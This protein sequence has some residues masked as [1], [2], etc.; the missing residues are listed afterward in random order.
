MV[1]FL[2]GYIFLFVLGTGVLCLKSENLDTATELYLYGW[3]LVMSSLTRQSMDYL[4][5]NFMAPLP[6]FPNP[7][8][9]A[10]V[11]PNVDTLYDACW[12]NHEVQ[13]DLIL[14]IPDTNDGLYYLFPLMDAWTNIVS[15]PGWRTTGK[16]DMTILIRGPFSN[17]TDPAPGEYDLVIKSTT[18]STYLLGRTNVADQNDL[19]PTQEQMFSYRLKWGDPWHPEGEEKVKAKGSASVGTT[20]DQIFAMSAEEYFN[21][22]AD[23]MLANPPILPQDQDI[24]VKMEAEYGLTAGE[25]WK[26]ADLT[27]DQQSALSTGMEKGVKLLYSYPVQKSN[28]WTLPNMQ[29]GNFSTDYYLRAYIGLVLYAANVPQDA[30]YYVSDLLDGGG[31]EYSF[32]F[33]PDTGG[34]P[35]TDMFWSV[36]MY[37]EEGYLV[38]NL[39]NIYSISSQQSLN[40]K[41]NGSLH[42][43]VSIDKP[44]DM[45]DTNWLPAPQEGENFQLTLRVYWPKEA[46]F[47]YAWVPPP[48]KEL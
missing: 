34:T 21:S 9:T 2:L 5:D 20:V 27:V 31:K 48:V 14:T 6:V 4:P 15:S 33:T 24:V 35:P 22:F 8:V 3:T 30:V 46:I 19:R 29:T 43:T 25:T 16:D 12:I 32:E 42:V 41:D 17:K 38:A 18:S 23:M 37:S 47:N 13:E 1:N 28:G 26:F 7:N 36:T 11:K 39:D 45:S 10:I 44:A 40:F